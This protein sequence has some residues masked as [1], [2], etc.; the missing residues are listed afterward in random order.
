[1]S[2]CPECGEQIT[3]EDVFC[4]YCGISIKPFARVEDSS[5]SE[6]IVDLPPVVFSKEALEALSAKSATILGNAAGKM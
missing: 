1:M 5:M 4:P 2:Y 3:K 6:T